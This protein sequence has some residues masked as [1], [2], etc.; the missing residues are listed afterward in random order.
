MDV[1]RDSTSE[2]KHLDIKAEKKD[3]ERGLF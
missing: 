3:S 1:F 2:E